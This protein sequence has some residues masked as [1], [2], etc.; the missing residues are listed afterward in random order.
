VDIADFDSVFDSAFAY[1]EKRR[2]R[3]MPEQAFSS[4]GSE[5]GLVFYFGAYFLIHYCFKL[6]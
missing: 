4:A 5:N 3:L 1:A 6:K 2:N